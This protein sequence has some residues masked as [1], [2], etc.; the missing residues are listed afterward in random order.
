MGVVGEVSGR[1]CGP[2]DKKK[3]ISGGNIAQHFKITIRED[4]TRTR[5]KIGSHQG[6][7]HME[8][9]Q[10]IEERSVTFGSLIAY[11]IT[12]AR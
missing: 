12:L 3:P 1:D 8:V 4:T 5:S 9:W 11:L 6:G 2:Q 10:T 7:A